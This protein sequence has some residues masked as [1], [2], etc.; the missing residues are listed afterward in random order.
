MNR[1]SFLFCFLSVSLRVVVLADDNADYVQVALHA[2]TQSSHSHPGH[3]MDDALKRELSSRGALVSKTKRSTS[4]KRSKRTVNGRADDGATASVTHKHLTGCPSGTSTACAFPNIHLI[5]Y[6]YNLY[7]A[8]PLPK[9]NY[10]VFPNMDTG[11]TKPLFKITPS[12]RTTAD[13][14]H[15]LPH[16]YGATVDFGCTTDFSTSMSR[17]TNEY[18]RMTSSDISLRGM[19]EIRAKVSYAVPSE[20]TQGG[21]KIKQSVQ[22][23]GYATAGVAATGEHEDKHV[24][25]TS[26][27][28]EQRM[29]RASAKCS[30]YVAAIDYSDMPESD[31]TFLADVTKLKGLDDKQAYHKLFQEYGTHYLDTVQMGAR[32]GTTFYIDDSKYKKLKQVTKGFGFSVSAAAGVAAKVAIGRQTNQ[33]GTKTSTGRQVQGFTK[34]MGTSQQQK[35]V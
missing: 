23:V 26:L 22:V 31:P 17:D 13:R 15:S 30:A 5:T 35:R 8:N 10:S 6:G 2:P 28:V 29:I 27:L 24:T 16:G 18:C 1:S 34:S 20:K 33:D 9:Y 14:R 25:T 11:L 19:A 21:V 32:Y 4:A 12:N 7:L 3:A